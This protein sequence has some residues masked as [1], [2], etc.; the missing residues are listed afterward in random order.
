MILDRTKVVRIKRE[1]RDDKNRDHEVTA[2]K[3]R[4][5]NT[6]VKEKAMITNPRFAELMIV[7]FMTIGTLQDKIKP[8]LNLNRSIYYPTRT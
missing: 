7:L 3:T 1:E 5:V 4:Y 8:Y 6:T 2:V